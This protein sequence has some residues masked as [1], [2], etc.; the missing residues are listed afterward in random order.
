[1]DKAERRLKSL[2]DLSA[3]FQDH[4][5]KNPKTS[6]A[7]TSNNEGKNKTDTKHKKSKQKKKSKNKNNSKFNQKASGSQNPTKRGISVNASRK[8]GA[9][10]I[11]KDIWGDPLD[12]KT[13]TKPVNQ[14]KIDRESLNSVNLTEALRRDDLSHNVESK[15]RLEIEKRISISLASLIEKK[16]GGDIVDLVLGLDIGSTSTKSIVRLPYIGSG[17]AQPV[18]AP[19]FIQA[20]EHPYYWR[21]VLWQLSN[22]RFSLFPEVDATELSNLKINF[23]AENVDSEMHKVAEI[24]MTAYAALMIRQS[25][26]WYVVNN[27]KSV[28]KNSF[29]LS[30]NVGFP[31]AAM[32]LDGTQ[33][34]FRVC[35]C[36]A[37]NL[38]VSG[39]P[40]TVETVLESIAKTRT[41]EVEASEEPLVEVYPELSGAISGFIHSSASRSG[42]Y[43][44]VDVGGL[45]LDCIFF[46]LRKDDDDPHY[47][48]YAADI[49]RYGSE[50]ISYWLRQGNDMSRAIAA[51]GN[52]YVNTVI[53]AHKK[54][55]RRIP[56]RGL[57]LPSEIPTLMIGGG[58]R[59][60]AHRKAPG[61]ATKSINNSV[62]AISLRVEDLAPAETDLDA[63]KLNGKGIG[64]L[65]V[66]SGLSLPRMSIPT[67]VKSSDIPDAEPLVVRNYTNAFIG[68]EQT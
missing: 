56:V 5:S 10:L 57:K 54:L 28:N 33:Q 38:A 35:C 29:F 13:E 47:A 67:W 40:I 25:L 11:G 49:S 19:G 17:A 30:I 58:R 64:R 15:D 61:W 24:Q 8:V 66:A 65:L 41:S 36:A 51:I 7:E 21:T 46:S 14:I 50:V 55:G 27:S 68:A 9:D 37:G 48:V 12:V 23:I 39:Q 34:R 42:T 22:G 59:S 6:R 52:F 2:R 3:V 43:V 62:Y 4:P 26:G 32:E 18:P 1:M 31:S 60:E 45:T 63:P 53:E 20:D 44:L 16:A